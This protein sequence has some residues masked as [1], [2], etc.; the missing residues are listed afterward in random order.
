MCSGNAQGHV[1][2]RKTDAEY[3]VSCTVGLHTYGPVVVLARA[4]QK[5]DCPN[6]GD[7]LRCGL[8]GIE[9]SHG[10]IVEAG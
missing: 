9:D 8:D 2:T 7:L 6:C 10:R 4:G 5:R 1:I 3:W